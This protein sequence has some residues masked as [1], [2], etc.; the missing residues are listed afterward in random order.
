MQRQG[1][2]DHKDRAP[3]GAGRNGSPCCLNYGLCHGKP[4]AAA[5]RLWGTG[6]VSPVKAVKKRRQLGRVHRFA[7]DVGYAE[8]C[9]F[10]I[11]GSPQTHLYWRGFW[12]VFK[13]VVQKD[14]HQALHLW[15]AARTHKASGH[16]DF[17]RFGL[18]GCHRIFD[19]LFA[20]YTTSHQL[21]RVKTCNLGS[22][23]KLTYE[24]CLK[25]GAQEKPLIDGL[26]LRNGNLEICLSPQPTE[27]TS[28]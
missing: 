3:R 20:A 4:Y 25:D 13:S 19:D 26:R 8:L 7:S 21:I 5:S 6:F 12:R 10:P 1:G 27:A 17:Q 9:R 16:L 28:L 14:S 11:L 15:S 24:I 2:F 18:L 22:L 23:F